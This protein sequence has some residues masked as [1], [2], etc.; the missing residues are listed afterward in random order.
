MN[1]CIACGKE[2]D[3]QDLLYMEF[4]GENHDGDIC[5]ECLRTENLEYEMRVE[6]I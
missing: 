6:C 1:K 4:H 5:S 3:E 2:F